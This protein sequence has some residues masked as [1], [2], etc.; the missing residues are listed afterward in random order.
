MGIGGM[1]GGVHSGPWCGGWLGV[2]CWVY[3]VEEELEGPGISR[4][5]DNVFALGIGSPTENIVCLLTL[6]WQN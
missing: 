4:E 2:V 3:G 5:L 6:H 1:V